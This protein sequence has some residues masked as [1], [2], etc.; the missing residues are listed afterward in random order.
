VALHRFLPSQLH[1]LP[2]LFHLLV[3]SFHLDFQLFGH[4]RLSTF[5]AFH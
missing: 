2:P 3:T 1:L 4:D 5:C